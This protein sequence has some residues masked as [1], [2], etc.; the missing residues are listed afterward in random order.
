MDAES[1]TGASDN[2]GTQN[3]DL[4]AA[5]ALHT[6]A[7]GTG[8]KLA[9]ATRDPIERRISGKIFK[10]DEGV[11]QRRRRFLVAASGQQ[12]AQNN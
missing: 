3:V 4:G 6:V 5:V 12:G 9:G 10:S 2:I 1:L 7:Q 11:A 8:Q